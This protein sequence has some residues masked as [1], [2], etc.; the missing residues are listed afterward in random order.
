MKKGLLVDIIGRDCTNGGITSGKTKAIL[1]GHGIP[2]VFESNENTPALKIEPGNGGRKLIAVPVEQ[3]S[4]QC[5]PMFGGNF[6]YSSDSR[7][8]SDQPIH[9]HDRFETWEDYNH[10]SI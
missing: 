4:D 7:F 2:E 9:V 1:C 10:L 5:G 6:V 3:P 8:P